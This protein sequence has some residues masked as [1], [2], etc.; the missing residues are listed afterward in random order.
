MLTLVNCVGL[1]S[2]ESVY[3]RFSSHAPFTEPSNSVTRFLLVKGGL[4]LV[5]SSGSKQTHTYDAPFQ[6]N[7]LSPDFSMLAQ[8]FLF[9]STVQAKP[10]IL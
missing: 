3:C 8:F 6:N 10:N 7:V 4:S 9:E 5:S 2:C 1:F